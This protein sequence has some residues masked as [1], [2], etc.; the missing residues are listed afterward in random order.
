MFDLEAFLAIHGHAIG[1]AIAIV[2]RQAHLNDDDR[3]DLT[4]EVFG[5]PAAQRQCGHSPVSRSERAQDVLCSPGDQ[6]AD[7]DPPAP[8]WTLAAVGAG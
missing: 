4:Q 7:R 1:R 5:A 6:R 8:R 3:H 2:C